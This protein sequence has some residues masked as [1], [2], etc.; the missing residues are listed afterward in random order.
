MR[1]DAHY[2]RYLL[3][4][5]IINMYCIYASDH[6]RVSQNAWIYGWFSIHFLTLEFLEK[7]TTTISACIAA[8]HRNRIRIARITIF[9]FFFSL[10]ERSNYINNKC[11][12]YI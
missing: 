11:I 10:I 9:Q 4:L 2:S 8:I 6:L 3:F 7:F 1:K 12:S 5:Y